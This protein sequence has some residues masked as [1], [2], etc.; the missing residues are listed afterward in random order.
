M[1]LAVRFLRPVAKAIEA[2]SQPLHRFIHNDSKYEYEMIKEKAEKILKDSGLENIEVIISYHAGFA[3]NCIGL[4]GEYSKSQES[5][6]K[7]TVKAI[8]A[9]VEEVDKGYPNSAWVSTTHVSGTDKIKVRPATV[10]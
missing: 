1:G 8:H 3:K 10:Y 7:Q 6:F 9:L 2:L 4:K 5:N